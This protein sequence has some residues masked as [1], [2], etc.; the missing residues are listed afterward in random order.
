MSNWKIFVTKYVLAQPEELEVSTIHD[1]DGELADY[2]VVN[3]SKKRGHSVSEKIL[4][5]ILSRESEKGNKP[6]SLICRFKTNKTLTTIIDTKHTVTTSDERMRHK[7]L[8][9]NPIMFQPSKKREDNSK[10]TKR[11][12][13][14]GQFSNDDFCDTH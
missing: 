12:K 3:E 2:L 14:Y 10:A 6:K 13:R 5:S 1:S 9:S 4:K 8:A 7:K 11:C